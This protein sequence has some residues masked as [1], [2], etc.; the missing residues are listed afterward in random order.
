LWCND[1]PGAQFDVD[2]LRLV[3]RGGDGSSRPQGPARNR[4]A[5][6]S[7]RGAAR[8]QPFTAVLSASAIKPVAGARPLVGPIWC[9]AT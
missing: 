2:G 6:W 4:L 8:M 5:G 7:R 9:Q 3:Y 1:A